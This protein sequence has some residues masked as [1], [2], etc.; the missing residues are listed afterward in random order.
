MKLTIRED[1]KNYTCTV[2]EVKEIFP[3]ENA[4]NIVRTV[5]NG[6]NVVISSWGENIK[7]N[8]Q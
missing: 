4:D 1:S 6:N 3:I 7:E 5:I 8:I 2:V